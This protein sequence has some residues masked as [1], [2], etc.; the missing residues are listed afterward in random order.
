M[1]LSNSH[2]SGFQSTLMPK[3]SQF[4]PPALPPKKQRSSN[5]SINVTTTPPVSPKISN[6]DVFTQH[7]IDEEPV[8]LLEIKENSPEPSQPESVKSNE[9]EPE[10]V[11][12]LRKKSTDKLKAKNLMEE[13]DIQQ[14]LE[15]KKDGENGPMILVGGLADALIIQA[16]RV[17]K[18][19]E[20][21][22]Q[23]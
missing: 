3:N 15:F 21:E 1:F 19:S 11:V 7:R 22:L 5:P 4:V 20:G 10:P 23:L 16:T 14:Y 13:L 8:R 17:Q 6:D 12:V 2:S 18:I 9:S